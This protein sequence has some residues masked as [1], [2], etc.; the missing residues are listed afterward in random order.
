MN[1]EIIDRDAAGRITKL[2]NN[3]K[4]LILP[5]VAIVIDPSKNLIAPKE[6]SS[7]FKTKLIIT[8][9]YLIKKHNIDV[10]INESG[11]LHNFFNF[12]D[13]IMTDSGAYQT[14]FGGKI[15]TSNKEI[16]NL[17]KILKPDIAVFLDVPSADLEFKEAKKTVKETLKRAKECKELVIKDI[18]LQKILWA[19]PIQGGSHLNLLKKSATEMNKLDFDIYPVGSI[20]PKLIRYDFLTVAEMIL[21]CKQNIDLNKPIHA[22]GLGLPQALSFFTAL[23]VDMF[24]CAAYALF[25]YDDRYMSLEGTHY[26]RDLKEFP[27]NCP[28]CSKSEPKDILEMEKSEREKWLA[29]HNL[30]VTYGEL[31][32]IRTAIRENWLWELVQ[33][34]ARAHPNL[35]F[36]LYHILKKYSKW[37]M[38]FEPITKKSA[39]MWSGE[40]TTYRPEILRAIKILR[41][42]KS[43]KKINISPFGKVPAGLYG[44]YPF[45][46]SIFPYNKKIR[47]INPKTVIKDTLNFQF[48]SGAGSIIKNFKIEFS[49]NTGKI[50]RIYDKNNNLLG[51]I[52]AYDGLFLPTK[53]GVKLLKNYMKKVIVE[54]DDAIK[55]IKQGKSIFVKFIKPKDEIY[56]GEE[57]LVIDKKNNII[58]EGKA[59]LNTIEMNQFKRGVAIITRLIF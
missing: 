2:E 33:Q 6:L 23:G 22:F 43:S 30:Y 52:R 9:S 49:K 57:V 27:C 4:K 20:V 46:Q 14:M 54:D 10:K 11:G 59:L 35:L 32:T 55:F 50:R 3:G 31:K 34:R 16:I 13:F 48:K 56:P 41:K 18:E 45:Y 37:L 42:I 38:R 40:E 29:K 28:L 58:A 36:A 15:K 1:F 12:N 53:E 8:N 25:A 19:G 24:D 5:D 51:T 39:I 21:T 26:L 47:K 7:N 17:Q 44:V